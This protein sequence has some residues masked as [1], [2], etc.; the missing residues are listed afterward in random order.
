VEAQGAQLG[1]LPAREQI[2]GVL[3]VLEADERPEARDVL[4]VELRDGTP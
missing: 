2:E 3:V 1:A 4:L